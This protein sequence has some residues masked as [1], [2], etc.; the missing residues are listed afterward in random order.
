MMAVKY[1]I[2]CRHES[3]SAVSILDVYE[4]RKRGV[5]GV[6]HRK[7]SFHVRFKG[8]DANNTGGKVGLSSYVT[9]LEQ[10]TNLGRAA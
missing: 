6:E 9:A 1:A 7:M 4:L 8:Y 3:K 2:S 5:L 10:P